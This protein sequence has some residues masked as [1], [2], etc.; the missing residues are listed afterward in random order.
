VIDESGTQADHAQASGWILQIYAVADEQ[1]QRLVTRTLRTMEGVTVE[2]ATSGS[3]RYVIVDCR[4]RA[5]VLG[6]KKF[7]CAVDPTA[8]VVHTSTDAGAGLGVR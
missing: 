4:T 2:L 3:D 7:L 5:M 6:V 1:V 8:V